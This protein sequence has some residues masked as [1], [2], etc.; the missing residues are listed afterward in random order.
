MTFVITY[1][2]GFMN[3]EITLQECENRYKKT[4][5]SSQGAKDIR[6]NSNSVAIK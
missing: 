3:I 4:V 1:C 6:I 2:F 5:L